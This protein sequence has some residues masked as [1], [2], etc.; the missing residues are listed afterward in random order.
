MAGWAGL[1]AYVAAWD[2]WRWKR[3]KTTLS[4]DFGRWLQQPGSRAVITAG[5]LVVTHHLYCSLM[6]AWCR[7]TWHMPERRTQ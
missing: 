3:G 6:P 2:V 7:R 4:E 1:A 5:W